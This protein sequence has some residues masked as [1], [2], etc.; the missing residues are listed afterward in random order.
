MQGD[1]KNTSN[2]KVNNILLGDTL[3]FA[4][5]VIHL[6]QGEEGAF[7]DQKHATLK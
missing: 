3:V 5:R 2:T 6:E 4:D 1:E 7:L